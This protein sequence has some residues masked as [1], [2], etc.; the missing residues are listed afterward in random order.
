MTTLA[1]FI[2]STGLDATL[3]RATV[4]QSGGWQAFRESAQYIV[5]HGAQSG[6]P[7]FI[8]YADTSAFFARHQEAIVELVEQFADDVGE[9]PIGLVQGFNGI[10]AT[11]AEIS[12]TLYGTPSK[13]DT[14]T[15]NALA[16]FALEEVARAYANN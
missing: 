3:I 16:W 13:H 8:Y 15:A 9:T 14:S 5:D 10:D 2:D 12:R 7:G 6:F 4:R 1:N 11:E